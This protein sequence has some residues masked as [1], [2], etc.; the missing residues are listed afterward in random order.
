MLDF[1]EELYSNQK[2]I[3]YDFDNTSFHFLSAKR[4]NLSPFIDL[5]L[6]NLKKKRGTYF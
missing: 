6:Q 1:F 4:I 2:F 3:E 5:F